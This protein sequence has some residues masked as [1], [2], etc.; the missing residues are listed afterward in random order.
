[1]IPRDDQKGDGM[2]Q[3]SERLRRDDGGFSLAEMLVALVLIALV[4]SGLVASII[5]GL[6]SVQKSNRQV[7]ANQLVNEVLENL[8]TQPLVVVAPPAGHTTATNSLPAVNRRSV[9]YTAAVTRTWVDSPCNNVLSAPASPHDYLELR[10]DI[11]WSDK[12]GTT[13]THRVDSIRTPLEG[14]QMPGGTSYAPVQVDALAS[15]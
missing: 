11:S 12:T 15:C 8:R 6:K 4:F 2:R 3:F 5:S 14:E 7:A 10:V 13:K 1:M 9:G